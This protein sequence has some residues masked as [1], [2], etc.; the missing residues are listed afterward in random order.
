[1]A[2]HLVCLT[3]DFDTH[4]PFIQ[5][6]LVTPT[7]LSR[8]E[9]G[10]VG[11]ERILGL[12][13]KYAIRSTWFTPGYTIETFPA[14]AA[15]IRDA[16]HEFAHHGWTH[17]PPALLTRDEE[18]AELERGNEAIRR[19]TGHPARGYRSPSWDLSPH[20]VEL[21]LEQGFVYDS[22]LMGHDYLPYRA[23]HGD[24]LEPR[25]PMRFGRETALIEMPISWHLDDAPHFLY[26]RMK[27]YVQQGLMATDGILRNWLDDFE[28]MTRVMGWGVLT[29]TFHPFVTGRGYTM[30][31]LE[32]LVLGLLE[33]GA[34][35]VPMGEAV[36][37]YATR[38]PVGGPRPGPDGEPRT[39]VP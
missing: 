18:R 28:Y 1:M 27:D 8:G 19:L 4:S 10:V 23:R 38:F 5:R 12:L 7:S 34:R 35:F 6:G 33:R 32:R 36:D 14:M 16:G 29:Y 22:S 26:L 17:T 39:V 31:M 11:A 24:V 20:T 9:F 37:E 25:Q 15:R 13:A 3:F 21:L 30:L 2:R